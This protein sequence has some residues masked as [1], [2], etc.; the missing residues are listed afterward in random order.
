MKSHTSIFICSK[1]R[2]KIGM[3]LFAEFSRNHKTSRDASEQT[4]LSELGR[5]FVHNLIRNWAGGGD[6][7]VGPEYCDN[8]LPQRR[9]PFGIPSVIPL[10]HW[11]QPVSA[12]LENINYIPSVQ[13]KLV[14]FRYWLHIGLFFGLY[15]FFFFALL[16]T[17]A[18]SIHEYGQENAKFSCG[19]KAGNPTSANATWKVIPLT[20]Q[21][22]RF[23]LS[24]PLKEPT[25]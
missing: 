5:A 7:S 25:I 4:Y 13:T 9:E 2:E 19:A 24:C 12:D 17:E 14:R 1:L 3:H 22:T 21:D 11:N 15:G 6:V 16:W 8:I 10:T 18:K 20:N 23:T